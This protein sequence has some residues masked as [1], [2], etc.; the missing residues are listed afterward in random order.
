VAVDE[1]GRVLVWTRDEP[2]AVF[3]GVIHSAMIRLYADL[4]G[5]LLQR[6]GHLSYRTLTQLFGFD[7]ACLEQV[8][9][10]L[11]FKQLARD[12]QGEG[13]EWTGG[14]SRVETDHQPGAPPDAVVEA[15]SA[16][17]DVVPL[18]PAPPVH[19]TPEAER[20]QLTVLFCDLVGSTQLSGQLDPEDWRAVVRAYQE[21]AAEV[22]Q[23]YEG[24]IA[25]YLGD[26]LLV[27]FGYPTAHED[28]ARRAVHTGLGMV[29]AIA[30]L[31]TRLAA[32]YGVELAVRVGAHTGPVVVGAMGSAERHEHLALGETPN[33]AARLEA[34]A[35]PNTV[36][37]SGVTAQLVQRAFVLEALGTQAL[38]GITA[39]MGVWRVVG[40]L[41]TLQEA[42]TLLPE[43]AKPLVGR[44]EELGLM[45]RR[46]EQS[47]AGQGQVVLIS[48][49]A[50]IDKSA[51]VDTLRAQVRREGLTRVTIRCS[52]YHTN[53]ALYPVIAH[54]H[55]A[56]R[57]E[58]YDTAEEK[59]AKREQAL[60]TVSLPLHEVVP[61]MAALVAVPLPDGRYPPL[62]LTP[63]QQRQQTYVV[64]W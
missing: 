30:T 10:A 54:V 11:V 50:G 41:E 43:D 20:R 38:K 39:P 28:D 61:L 13:L 18:L 4:V 32:Q 62:P 5:A 7:A 44:S 29:Q 2:L 56:L 23:Q 3:P 27:Y 14:L 8:R 42:T 22:I 33:I 63:L 1:G 53:S 51:L 46:W 17:L 35:A 45:V 37:I 47:K 55:Q 19:P 6:E 59:L 34:L 9:Q 40:P 60:Q 57:F 26:G 24:H 52:P 21:A 31:N 15:A 49:E 64:R 16:P 12:V 48:G 25:Q 36:V 58:R